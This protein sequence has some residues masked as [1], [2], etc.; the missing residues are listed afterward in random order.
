[1]HLVKDNSGN[2]FKVDDSLKVTREELLGTVEKAN[3]LL[4]RSNVALAEFD[5][6]THVISD[7]EAQATL[8][9]VTP[10]VA[11]EVPAP[12]PVEAPVAAPVEQ[13]TQVE[14]PQTVPEPTPA[15]QAQEIAE[16]AADLAADLAAPVAAPVA[17]VAETPAPEQV[18]TQ[19][20]VPQPAEI[21]VQ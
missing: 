14:T 20:P 10:V 21:I 9:S 7:E 13:I 5:N 3:E 1:M 8:D 17:P 2:I 19:P 11:P 16:D 12:A 15:E 18:A 4:A 6:L